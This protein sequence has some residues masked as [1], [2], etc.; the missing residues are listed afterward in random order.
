MQARYLT[1]TELDVLAKALGDAW[2][3]LEVARL[4]GMRIGDVLKMRIDDLTPQG[5]VYK[6]EKT[7]K[8]GFAA[9]P[10]EILQALRRQSRWGWCFPSPKAK[11]KH[12][13]RQAAWQRLKRGAQRAKIDLAGAS[14]HALRK[15]YAVE[16]LHE[17]GLGAV[18]RALQHERADVTELYALADWS[19]GENADKPLLRKDLLRIATKIAELLKRS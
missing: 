5:V 13:T 6:A 3:P 11:G 12:L 19:T 18:Q 10:P 8:R 4:T 16:L 9:L 2:L 7:G 14:P 1:K 17:Q 15:S